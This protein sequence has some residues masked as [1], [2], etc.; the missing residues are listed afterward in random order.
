MKTFRRALTLT[1]ARRQNPK[2]LKDAP[3]M[4]FNRGGKKK[5]NDALAVAGEMH[6]AMKFAERWARLMQLRINIG[7]KLTLKM[8]R[9]ESLAAERD[10]SSLSG[11]EFTYAKH[12]LSVV[13][14]YA[15][16]LRKVYSRL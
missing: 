1:A 13:W 8:M 2:I 16:A 10:S 14:K 5:W 9:F 11:H 6:N 7:E 12:C 4:L 15:P 3:P